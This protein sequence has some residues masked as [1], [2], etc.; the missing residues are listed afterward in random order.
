MIVSIKLQTLAVAM[1]A[2]LA[3]ASHAA[4][5]IN[6]VTS[7]QDLAALAREVLT[8]GL[9][10]ASR[11]AKLDRPQFKTVRAPRN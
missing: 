11:S 10:P 4:P 9:D 8:R 3:G 6:L 5:K 7:T 2:A 1:G